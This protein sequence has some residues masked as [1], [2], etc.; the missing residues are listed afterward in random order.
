MWE[1]Q[2]AD[3]GETWQPLTRGPFPLYACF[4][5]SI[6]T[7]SGAMVICGRFPGI[8]C[9]LSLDNGMTW[10]GATVDVSS[11]WSQGAMV[12]VADDVVLYTYGGRGSGAG[13]KPYELRTQLLKVD[14]DAG[15]LRAM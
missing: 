11:A 1:A 15:V 12:E 7:R 14:R 2:S 10:T 3:G 9:H 13:C 6:T 4:Y 5:S 8:T